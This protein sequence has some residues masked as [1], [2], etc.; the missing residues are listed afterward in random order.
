M[1][2]MSNRSIPIDNE[3]TKWPQ[4]HPETV[5]AVA[6]YMR[7]GQP[8]SISD[9][10]GIVEELETKLRRWLGIPNILTTNSGTTAILSAIFALDLPLGSEIIAPTYTFHAS[11][12]PAAHCGLAPVLVD[13]DADTANISASHIEEATTDRTRCVVV[14]H[15]WGHPAP[16][17]EIVALCKKRGIYL[18]E[19][20]S[21]AYGSKI[22]GK[23]V[24]TFGD[25]AIFSM[26]ANKMLPAG[27]G[28][29]LATRSTTIYER[30]VLLGH[31]R[32]RSRRDVQTP[33]LRGL[34][35]TGFGLKFRLH[36]LAALIASKEFDHLGENI[37]LRKSYVEK[38]CAVFRELEEIEVPVVRPG[39][40]MGCYFGFRPRYV[41]GVLRRESGIVDQN[42][43]IEILRTQGI[44]VR[45]PSVR[46]LHKEP[47]FNSNLPYISNK[48]PHW[49][50][51][52]VGEFT[53]CAEYLKGRLSLPTFSGKRAYQIVDAYCD[54]FQKVSLSYR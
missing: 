45:I 46:P 20:C 39:V 47:F 31:Y 50:P 27:E 36:P 44:N 8:I 12:T 30:A 34:S 26:Q 6:E 15:T 49:K 54:A 21:H 19:D 32:G 52:F 33:E 23:M 1:T 28:G 40:E 2:Q 3:Y 4:L 53:G 9:G 29:F 14:N 42:S 18:I 43:Y 11:V 35:E 17:D 5:D 13:V 10:S 7:G 25:I 37:Q 48:F 16:M 22:N 41:E 51:R 38:L 24:G